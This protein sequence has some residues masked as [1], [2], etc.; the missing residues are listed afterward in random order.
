MSFP[1]VFAIISVDIL[2]RVMLISGL[3]NRKGWAWKLNWVPIVFIWLCPTPQCF[4][5]ADEFWGIYVTKIIASGLVWMWPNYVYWKKRRGLFSGSSNRTISPA[6]SEVEVSMPKAVDGQLKA[7]E[8]PDIPSEHPYK[9]ATEELLDIEADIQ[10]ES[11]KSKIAPVQSVIV[12]A[13]QSQRVT[14]W[15]PNIP[16]R[17]IFVILTIVLLCIAEDASH[18]EVA[19]LV[20]VCLSAA[21][22]SAAISVHKISNPF[23]RKR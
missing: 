13:P 14:G 12:T 10:G 20:T 21:A 8:S 11:K 3:H 1:A 5:S 17:I 23:K 19:G 22:I 6:M 2:M 18:E 16:Q 4:R 7:G 15:K 9:M